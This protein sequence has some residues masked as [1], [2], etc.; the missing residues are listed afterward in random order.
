MRALEYVRSRGPSRALDCLEAVADDTVFET[1][2]A[3]RRSGFER[4]DHSLL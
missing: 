1:E 2:M 4:A 3:A